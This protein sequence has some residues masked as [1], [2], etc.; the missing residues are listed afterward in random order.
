MNVPGNDVVTDVISPGGGGSHDKS[1]GPTV[2]YLILH[3]F[4]K[5]YYINN[6]WRKERVECT[7]LEN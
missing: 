7:E 6:I 4:G 3:Y 2:L 1:D 5:N